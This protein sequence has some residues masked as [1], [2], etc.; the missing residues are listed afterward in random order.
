MGNPHCPGILEVIM[1]WPEG[2]DFGMSPEEEVMHAED[3]P[4]HNKLPANEKQYAL[5]TDGSCYIVGKHRRWKAAV[6]SATQEVTEATK[7]E[8]ELRQFA[9]VKE[10]QLALDIAE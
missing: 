1:D 3:T 5:C 6:W 4:P 9:K 8:G 2:K 7:G 10:I